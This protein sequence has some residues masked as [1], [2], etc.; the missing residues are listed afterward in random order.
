MWREHLIVDVHPSPF[1]ISSV[2]ALDL[3][4][5]WRWLMPITT[6]S[7]CPEKKAGFQYPPH[8]P[9]LRVE[10]T[11][12]LSTGYLLPDLSVAVTHVCFSFP[13]V[14]SP[15]YSCSYFWLFEIYGV[16]T[17]KSQL[18]DYKNLTHTVS[19]P[20]FSLS[21][22][23]TSFIRIWLSRC[24]SMFEIYADGVYYFLLSHDLLFHM[25]VYSR[26][27]HFLT[28]RG[29]SHSLPASRHFIAH[30]HHSL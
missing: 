26:H 18:H 3:K 27:H 10:S 12:F 23:L 28:L 7:K 5:L 4:Q 15:P 24:V 14:L 2:T 20:D 11:C 16:F 25:T 17:Y 8:A 22:G 13:S 30:L 29:P 21:K 19:L 9:R 6:Q 1:H